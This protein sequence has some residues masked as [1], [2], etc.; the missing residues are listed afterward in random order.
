MSKRTVKHY[1]KEEWVDFVMHQTPQSQT[2]LMQSHLDAGCGKC[3]SIADLW[4]RVAEVASRESASEP[5]A[6]AVEHVRHSFA[7]VGESRQSERNTLIP[8]LAFDSLWQ[9]AFAGVRS[10]SSG[11]RHVVYVSGRMSIDMRLEPEPKSERINLAGQISLP[12][13]DN[14][15]FPPTPVVVSGRSGNLAATTTNRFGEFHV[16]FIPEPGLQVSFDI[17]GKDQ[18]IVPLDSTGIRSR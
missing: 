3:G 7:L 2:E 1:S 18:I 9:P 13:M 11:S 8:R 17:I 6:S 15:A 14:E 5:P 12:P 16:A 4:T 10:G